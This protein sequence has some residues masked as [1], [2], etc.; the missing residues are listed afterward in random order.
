M[1]GNETITINA[2]GISFPNFSVNPIFDVEKVIV[3]KDFA[4]DIKIGLTISERT[5][6]YDQIN[7]NI[8]VKLLRKSDKEE[9]ST[10]EIKSIYILS[11][12]TIPHS[13]R[14]N[15]LN[16]F[17]QTTLGQLQGGWVAKQ[18]NSTLISLIPNISLNDKSIIEDIKKRIVE[19]WNEVEE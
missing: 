13:F 14:F 15:V 11:A 12:T 16:S 3:E 17:L 4:W 10:I 6:E 2:K 18:S 8:I 1:N 5:S 7:I 19:W 9:I